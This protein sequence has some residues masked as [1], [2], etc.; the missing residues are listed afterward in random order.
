MR[1][2]TVFIRVTGIHTPESKRHRSA[3]TA[4]HRTARNILYKLRSIQQMMT[5]TDVT[6]SLVSDGAIIQLLTIHLVAHVLRDAV[7]LDASCRNF[8]FT[9]RKQ[10]T[11]HFTSTSSSFR[12]AVLPLH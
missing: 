3:H 2:S 12:K 8:N 5:R 11:V 7:I 10:L 1:T 4:C 9:V 6:K